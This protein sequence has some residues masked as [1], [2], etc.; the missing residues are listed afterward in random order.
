MNSD[1]LNEQMAYY[2]A[3][4]L[5]YDEITENIEELKEAYARA[6]A[7]LQK[8]G[9]Y[10]QVL[11]LA[12]GTGTWTQVL[13]PI[14]H[15]ITAIDAA[16]EMLAIARQKL[17]DAHVSYQQAD[18]F[19]WEPR[20]EY[21]LVLFAN[22]LSHVLPKDLDAFL[23][24]ISRAVRPGGHLAVIDQ[25]APFPEDREIMT[26]GEGGSLY[27]RRSLRNGEAFTIVKVFYEVTNLQ[28]M[29]AALRFEVTLHHLSDL[30]FFLSARRL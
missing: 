26:A 4:A 15:D 6:K 29:L 1:I 27:A 24:K 21:D 10:E 17:G 11:E 8:M 23:G 19:Q 16:P 7:L 14:A 30:F 5:E 13:L 2:R 18:V 25:S 22:W 9:Q 3:Q 28:E 20:Q 12:C